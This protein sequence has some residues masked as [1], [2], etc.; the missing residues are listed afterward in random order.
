[1]PGLVLVELFKL[2]WEMDYNSVTYQELQFLLIPDH[3]T[4]Q[5]VEVIF[6]ITLTWTS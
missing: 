1:M 4:W 6:D 5:K 2:A 3:P